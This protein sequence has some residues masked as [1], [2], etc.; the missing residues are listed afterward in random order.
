[1]FK[2]KSIDEYD[3]LLSLLHLYPR[4]RIG[5]FII[6]I[7]PRDV[8]DAA[9]LKINAPMPTRMN[10]SAK[11]KTRLLVNDSLRQLDPLLLVVHMLDAAPF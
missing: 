6:F 7:N 8:I 11:D 10:M 1:M 5:D 4:R 9:S 2:T 3:E